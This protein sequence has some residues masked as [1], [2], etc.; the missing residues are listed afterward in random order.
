[1]LELQNRLHRQ[2]V[3]QNEEN[4]Q[5]ASLLI[6]IIIKSHDMTRADA[7]EALPSFP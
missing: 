5:K 1:M 6:V 4:E 7:T 2:E 3:C